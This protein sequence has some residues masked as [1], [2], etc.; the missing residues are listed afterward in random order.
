MPQTARRKTRLTMPGRKIL[1]TLA[2]AMLS[3]SLAGAAAAIAQKK[4]KKQLAT[5]G[6]ISGRVRVDAGVSAAGVSVRLRQGDSEVAETTTNAKGEFVFRN[7]APGSYGL[8][9]RKAGLQVGRLE[10]LEV[11]A[12]QTV[13]LKGHLFLP[14]DE[15]SIAFIKRSVFNAEGRSLPVSRAE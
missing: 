5:T 11:R 8:T 4:S 3:L 10:N 14:I 1:Q 7:V 12:G 6:D 13:S 2:V 15:G 9:L